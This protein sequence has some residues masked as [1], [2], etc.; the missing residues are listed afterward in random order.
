[1][2]NYFYDLPEELQE[3]I[4]KE[5]H[6]MKMKEVTKEV[7]KGDWVKY[8][9]NQIR[10]DCWMNNNLVYYL[11]FG[12]RFGLGLGFRLG[13]GFKLGFE[14]GLWFELGFEN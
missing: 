7:K 3:M 8:D 13:F 9:I 5:E 1:M 4:Y 14:L 6:K 11:M 2:P 12:W 10:I